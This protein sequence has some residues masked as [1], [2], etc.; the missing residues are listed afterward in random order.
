MRSGLVGRRVL[1]PRA[2]AWG[3]RVLADVRA[4][5]AEGVIAPLIE[6][7]APVDVVSR[8]RVFASLAA[9]VYDWVFVTSAS[10]VEQLL[11]C[12]IRVPIRTKIAAVGRATGRALAAAGMQ[13]DF[14]PEGQT[15]AGA[16]I[17]QWCDVHTPKDA[18]RGLVLRSDMAMAAVSDEL[19]I[20]GYQVDVGIA[21]RTVGV[22]VGSEVVSMLTSG[23]I[24]VVLVTS[25]SVARELQQQVP[26]ISPNVVLVAI[27][28]GTA[29]AAEKLGL[30]P[31]LVSPRQCVESMLDALELFISRN[32]EKEGRK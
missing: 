5:G 9:G 25:G 28:Q 17:R 7:R 29:R 10:T 3:D 2:G 18:G 27:G 6:V 19:E 16:M 14:L 30:V 12:G 21:Y 32:N 4:R 24:D 20:Q 11:S 8:D 15:S 31:R 1:I 26:R 22:D 23:D 13:V